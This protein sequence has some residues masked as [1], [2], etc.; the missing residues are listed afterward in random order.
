M[1]NIGTECTHEDQPRRQ[2]DV[3]DVRPL[4]TM[5][6]TRQKTV[7]VKTTDVEIARLFI[8][9]GE[10]IPTYEAQGEIIVHCL[11]G[12]LRLDAVGESHELRAGQ[13]L[14]LSVNEP[15]SMRSIAN[16][17]LL[18]SIVLPKKGQSVELIGS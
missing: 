10:Q 11:D 13:L 1:T 16:S 18:L 7:L 3:I 4:G 6:E 17:L 15:F 14:Y 9:A 12:H 5:P 2:G 8:P